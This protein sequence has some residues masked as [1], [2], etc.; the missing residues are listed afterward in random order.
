MTW[1]SSHETAFNCSAL[2]SHA[3]TSTTAMPLN[4]ELERVCITS[5]MI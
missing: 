3:M 1:V 2:A 5:L 4:S